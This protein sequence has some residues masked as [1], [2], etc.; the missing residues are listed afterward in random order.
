MEIR[1]RSCIRQLKRKDM[2]DCLG[3]SGELERKW[4]EKRVCRYIKKKKV[5]K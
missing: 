2:W 1:Q 3:K 5:K 4:T